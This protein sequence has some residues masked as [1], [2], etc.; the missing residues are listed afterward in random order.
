MD[1][2]K[3]MNKNDKIFMKKIKTYYRICIWIVISVIIFSVLSNFIIATSQSISFNKN[4]KKTKTVIEVLP[5]LLSDAT[6]ILNESNMV[7]VDEV[8]IYLLNKDIYDFLDDSSDCIET[9]TYFNTNRSLWVTNKNIA[10]DLDQETIDSECAIVTKVGD[11]RY[12][13]IRFDSICLLDIVN[14]LTRFDD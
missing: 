2:E 12:V 5:K 3:R 4:L 13:C 10:I 7:S 14:P 11:N 8:K 6:K 9:K 1:M